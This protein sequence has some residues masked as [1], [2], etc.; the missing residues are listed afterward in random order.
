MMK[1]RAAAC[2]AAVLMMITGVASAAQSTY[3]FPYEGL[4]YNQQAG[5]TVLTQTNLREHE[6]LIASLGTT[7]EA[8]LASYMAAGIVMEVIPDEGGQISVSVADAGEFAHVSHMDD[9]SKEELEA[10]AAQFETSGLYESVGLTGTKPV[11]VRMES[12]AMYG[13]MPVYTVRYATLHLGRLCMLTQTI[14]DRVPSAQDDDRMEKVL[15]SIRFLSAMTQPTPTPTPAPTATPEPTPVPTPGVAQVIAEEGELTVEGVPAYTN[16]ATLNISGTT[17]AAKDV[18]VRVGD[19]TLGK[20]TAKKDGSYA[21]RVTLPEEGELTVAVMTDDAEQMLSVHYELA[22]APLEITAP[23]N[24]TFTGTN[25]VLRGTTAANA[26]VFIEAEGY[27]TNV[28][29]NGNGSWS[30]RLYFDNEGT[31][32]YTVRTKPSGYAEARVQVTLT[33][34]LTEKEWIAAFRVKV[35]DPNYDDLAANVE[36]YAGKQVIERG[37]VME[38]ADYDGTPCALICTNNP[39]KGIWTEPM[40]V[41]MEGETDIAVEDIVSVYL[42]CEG[43]SLPADAAYYKDSIEREAPVMRMMHWTMNK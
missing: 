21:L 10:F 24:T 26:T 38:F 9:L 3:V 36:N 22:V 12:S 42:V 17:G 2:L 4:R 39:A 8:I 28:K 1:H 11:C 31:Q 32:T 14:V 23:E 19:K 7:K 15:S 5:E 6:A 40:W 37:K 18:T 20:T 25:I 34:E 16:S 33:R 35:I 27:K 13:T 30:A 29:A 41:I 43:L